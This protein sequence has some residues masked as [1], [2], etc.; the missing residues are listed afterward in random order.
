MRISVHPVFALGLLLC[1]H[2]SDLSA[3]SGQPE[4]VFG[5]VTPATF[6]PTAYDSASSASAVY[7]FDHGEVNFDPSYNNNPGFSI[8]FERH[9]RIRILN[10]N[11]LG[12]ATL[13]I[14]ATHRRDYNAEIEDVRGAT[15]NLEDGKVVVSRLDKSNIFK[16]KNGYVQIDKIAFPNVREGS[17]IEYSYRIVYP[18]FAYIPEWEFQ[19]NYPELWSQYDV[20]VPE[21]YDYFVKT[22]G[23]RSFTIDTTLY[24]DAHFP[25]YFAGFSGSW[26]GRAV[27]RIW[28]LQDVAPLEKR[29]PYTTTLRNHVQKVQF[30][31]SAIRMSGYQKTYLSTWDELTTELLKNEHFGSSLDD[32]NHWMDEEIKKLVTK[33]DTSQAAAYRLFAFLRDQFSSNGQEVIYQSQPMKKTWEDRK[34]NVAD[35]N[36]LLTAIYRREGFDASPVILSTRSHGFPLYQFPLLMDYNYVVTRVRADGQYYLLD[37]T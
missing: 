6:A 1:F 36:L 28:A 13:G 4:R 5:D 16:D 3:Q 29:E 14:S 10:K 20:T 26:N 23:Y 17:V 37:A 33:G 2:F 18:S 25:V 24:P 35:I 9:T 11:G 27:H 30:Q 32:R 21:L 31:L 34:G 8:V 22:Q 12:L 7:L 15:Y 19:G